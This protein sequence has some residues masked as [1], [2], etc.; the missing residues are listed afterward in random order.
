MKQILGRQKVGLL[1]SAVLSVAHPLN[2]VEIADQIV[3][4]DGGAI[5][6]AGTHAG[7]VESSQVYRELQGAAS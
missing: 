1:L 3:V 2:T 4:M 7:L 6:G 5:D